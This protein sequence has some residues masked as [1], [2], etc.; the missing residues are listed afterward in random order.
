[1]HSQ[2]AERRARSDDPIHAA[3]LEL[4]HHYWRIDRPD[5]QLMTRATYA[6]DERRV[7]EHR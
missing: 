7:Q 3:L 4:T 2:L 5:P 1:M 6:R